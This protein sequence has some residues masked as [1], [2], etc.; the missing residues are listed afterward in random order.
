MYFWIDSHLFLA[1]WKH[2][3]ECQLPLNSEVIPQFNC[4]PLKVDCLLL[5]LLLRWF[6]IFIILQLHHNGPYWLSSG[7]KVSEGMSIPPLPL[8]LKIIFSVLWR[9]QFL[10]SLPYWREKYFEINLL[11]Y[12][13]TEQA[14]VFCIH[15]CSR[16]N[17]FSRWS[18]KKK[19]NA[20]KWKP[21]F[22]AQFTS[23]GLKLLTFG[24]WVFGE[25]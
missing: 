9:R 4:C 19:K 2:S 8:K 10:P 23:Q 7:Y 24:H 6:F 22:N 16:S 13:L 3:S 5:W 14:L 21:S 11:I 25:H 18:K 1:H 17:K 20:L 15:T 12:A